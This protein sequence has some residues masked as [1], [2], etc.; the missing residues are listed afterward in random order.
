MISVQNCVGGRKILLVDDDCDFVWA[1]GNVLK[2]AGYEVFGAAN[3]E[4]GIGILDEMKPDLVLLDYHMPGKDGLSVAEEMLQSGSKP[5]IIMVTAYGEVKSAVRAMKMGV[6]DYIS[7]PVDNNDLLFTV[8]RA[9]E[10]RD[11]T[12]EVQHLK[13][14]L[15]GRSS[16]Y[17]LMGYGDR[18]RNLVQLIEKV[19]PTSFSVLIEGESGAGKEL[20]AR[21]IHD[22]GGGENRPFVAVD[23]G[24]IPESLIESELF[25]YMKGAFT[26]AGQDKPGQFELAEGGTLF[27][28]EIGNL[29]Y[30]AQQKLLRAM[31]ERTVQRL[32]ATKTQP[33]SARIIAA[34]NRPLEKHIE[35]G[36][37]R[38]DL[39]FRLKEF[40]IR[41][42]PLRERAEDIPHLANRFIKEASQE[43]DKPCKGLSKAALQVLSTYAWPGNVR[44]LRNVIRQAVLLCEPDNLLHPDHFMMDCVAPLA[45]GVLD[46]MPAAPV[47]YD[48]ASL[49]ESVRLVADYAEQRII[50]QALADA[51]GNKSEV[52]RRLCID[53]KTLLRKMKKWEEDSNF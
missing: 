44:E 46:P 27:L 35:C 52:A 9:I 43:L 1:T 20:V 34:T 23:C 32:G 7:K 22:L 36:A 16:L 10:T 5:S 2:A 40:V 14:V 19:G 48:G 41:V 3:G 21:A 24:A 4:A 11:L 51:G 26:G 18:I 47:N 8:Q 42:S 45:N 53:Y 30:S 13:K 6:Y 31:Q 28:D 29:P 25:G 37:F 17:E 38:S 12:Q 39:Y 50:M 15:N 33:F 49:K